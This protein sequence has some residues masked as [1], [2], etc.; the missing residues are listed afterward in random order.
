MGLANG[1]NRC[2]WSLWG[3]QGL[4]DTSVSGGGGQSGDQSAVS[5]VFARVK[6]SLSYNIPGTS[7]CLGDAFNQGANRGPRSL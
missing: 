3:R 7:Y 4:F 2:L 5:G 6:A 1:P